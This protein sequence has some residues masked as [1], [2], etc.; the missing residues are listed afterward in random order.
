MIK[1]YTVKITE[2]AQIQIG[3]ITQ[4]IASELFSSAIALRL[5]AVFEKEIASLSYLPSR[6]AFIKEE[7]WHSEG[8]RKKVVKNFLVYFWIDERKQIIQVIAVVYARR[9]QVKQ[10]LKMFKHS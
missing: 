2:Q 7:P 4:Y 1:K 9:D 5:L 3:E 6:Y 10:L 8:V